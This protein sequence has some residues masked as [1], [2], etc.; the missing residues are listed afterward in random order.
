[1]S[2]VT[3]EYF[4]IAAVSLMVLFYALEKL[5]HCFVGLFAL[6][7]G[8][9]ATYALLIESYPFMLAEGIWSVVAMRRWF[10]QRE[11]ARL[12]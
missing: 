9:A 4:G 12:E 2:E 3:I 1:M 5:H 11:R 8:F 6:A 7:C 10:V